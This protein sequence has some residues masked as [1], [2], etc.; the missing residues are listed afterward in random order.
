MFV[1]VHISTIFSVLLTC[2]LKIN[3]LLFWPTL[4]RRPAVASA[5]RQR[6]AAHHRV[7]LSIPIPPGYRSWRVKATTFLS[8]RPRPRLIFPL[9]EFFP[10]DAMHPRYTSHEPVSVSVRVCHKS[11]FCRDG[12][13]NLAG[14]WH[15]SFLPPVLH[16][17]K[18]K[19]GYLQNK[20]TSLWN[21]VL[22]SVLRKFRHGI[23]IVETCYQLSS[24][25]VNAQ[26]VINWAD[27]VGQLSR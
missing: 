22:N 27:V 2:S 25:N 6:D 21:F 24:R 17:V 19:F 11:V 26:S 7:A 18:R 5:A 23:S 10:R 4:Y 15:V 20:G 3:S 12:W 8:A 16:C 9:R 14:F 1:F 13:T